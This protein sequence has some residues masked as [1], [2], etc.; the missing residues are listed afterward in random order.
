VFFFA[1][2][3]TA[4]YAASKRQPIFIGC[5]FEWRLADSNQVIFMK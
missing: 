2:F 4:P 5:L 1:Y 3:I